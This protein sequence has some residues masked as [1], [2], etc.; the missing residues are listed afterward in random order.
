MRSILS[1]VGEAPVP[2]TALIDAMLELHQSDYLAGWSW[3]APTWPSD[4]LA[5]TP[6]RWMDEL[7]D[8]L[9]DVETFGRIAIV[10]WCLLDDGVAAAA[11]D[12]GML[13][14]VA[15]RVHPQLSDFL[16][17][18]GLRLLRRRAPLAALTVGAAVPPVD[19]PVS[20]PVV[21]A[22]VARQVAAAP[23]TVDRWAISAGGDLVV[24]RGSAWQVV[25]APGDL[26]VQSDS[27]A[28]TKSVSLLPPGLAAL[29]LGWSRRTVL[30]V[31]ETGRPGLLR[32]DPRTSAWAEDRSWPLASTAAVGEAGAAVA[33]TEP[34]GSIVWGAADGGG[35]VPLPGPGAA[36]GAAV[37]VAGDHVAVLGR[38]GLNLG[39]PDRPWLEVELPASPDGSVIA[40]TGQGVAVGTEKGEVL[41]IDWAGGG[42]V[43]LDP[44]P[45]IPL[46]VASGSDRL[47]ALG[48]DQMVVVLSGVSVVGR[49]D[50]PADE[51]VT[52]VALSTD[53]R[54]LLV[55][56]AEASASAQ[57]TE[58]AQVVDAAATDTNPPARVRIWRLDA[59]PE[60][61][62]TGYTDDTPAGEDLLGIGPTVDALAAI[63]AAKQVQPPLSIGLFGAWGSG[64]SFFM[65]QLE[66]RVG[67]LS[68]ESHDS[69][70][71]QASLWAWR[72][73]RQVRFN[74]W[75][76]ASADV[77]AGLLE[78]LVRELARPGGLGT[79]TLALPPELSE[80]ERQRVAKLAGAV[81]QAAASEEALQA[82][83]STLVSAELEVA[84]R[85]E[86]LELARTKVRETREQ[87]PTEQLSEQVRA[88]LGAALEAAGLSQLGTSLDA[89]LLDIARARE[90]LTSTAG[91]AQ[92]AG[93]RRLVLGLVVVLALGLLVT[94]TLR[95]LDVDLAGAFGLL[96]ALL[97]SVAATA[98]WL[99]S[100]A[101]GVTRRLTA[102][103]DAER[104]ALAAEAELTGA[105]AA[106][107]RDVAEA[108]QAVADATQARE[109]ALSDVA[110]A[111][112][113]ADTATP[114]GLL[115]EYL[116]GRDSS[117]DYRGM[118]GLIGTVRRDLEVI[119]SA[120]ASNNAEAAA[121]PRRPPDEA[122]NRIV[123]YVDDLDRCRPAV[124][125]K[126]LEAVSMLLTF[127]M[128]VVVVAVDAHWISKSLADVY[129][130]LLTGG[131]VTPDNY[132]EKIF[133]LPVWLERPS[134]EAAFGMARALLATEAGLTTIGAASGPRRD[135]GA[136]AAQASRPGP[137]RASG[138]PAEHRGPDVSLA[139]TPP[140]PVSLEPGEVAALAA[141]APL[142]SRSPRALKRY[143]NTYRVLK[144]LVDADDLE[145]VRM[146]LAVATGRPDVGERLLAEIAHAPA[147]R[148]LA[149]LVATWPVADSAWLRDSLP[150]ELSTWPTLTCAR[151]RPVTAEVRRFVF[152]AERPDAEGM[153][154][155]EA[156]PSAASAS[157]SADDVTEE[158]P[159]GL[160]TDG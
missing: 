23:R 117:T 16:T 38:A 139:T 9:V 136:A 95:W 120:V 43:A 61:R 126:V 68:R 28:L 106:A 159:A 72:S 100:A 91:L 8:L 29:A 70:R 51:R 57:A 131:D 27:I 82:A 98:R 90:T 73:I 101:S 108:R 44:M 11:Q 35:P 36:P 88:Q 15:H 1:R 86:E 113:R 21:A 105:L 46:R 13:A 149:D 42:R 135:Q 146:L 151:L 140:A 80:L 145:P 74:A 24:G 12:S 54:A 41:L 132:L 85:A 116:E 55:A 30:H 3:L 75:H 109:A 96:T 157:G 60:V 45:G 155:V 107:R 127:P 141:L 97:G 152:H 81:D 50:A 76:Y 53:D 2:V 94:T 153:A 20:A 83:Q 58:A 48:S 121:D 111:R 5:Q 147:D 34:S 143:L 119:S 69:G 125:V 17:A 102:L 18:E 160:S 64:K 110:E 67:Q 79:L 78:H 124:V 52:A 63:V 142:V 156:G 49:W 137:A 122:V 123:L 114:G 71:P 56:T 32:F 112:H 99:T 47:V 84:Q 7:D 158:V 92:A 154:P 144:A 89:T 138:T 148:T 130:T 4:L 26:A 93:Q 104:A 65:R 118:L 39:G 10:G 103:D 87:G 19:L 14:G 22:A 77:W 129:P 25:P 115:I 59:V 134:D 150:A 40:A 31:V 133:Q 66:D 128:F 62:L 6:A 33:D 37:A